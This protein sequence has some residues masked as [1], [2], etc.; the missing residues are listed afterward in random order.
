MQEESKN[1]PSNSVSTFHNANAV[2]PK[3]ETVR[4]LKR[5]IKN[6]SRNLTR[7]QANI[8]KQKAK[9]RIL[10]K[11]LAESSFAWF[12]NAFFFIFGS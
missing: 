9:M 2:D 11:Q 12:A 3:K 1:E 8:L 6:V 10:E 5:K 7:A 4:N